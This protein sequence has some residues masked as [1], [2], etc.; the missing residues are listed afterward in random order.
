LNNELIIGIHGESSNITRMS[1]DDN[2]IHQI[3]MKEIQRPIIRASFLHS[4]R[5]ILS[6]DSSGICYLTDIISKTSQVIESSHQNDIDEENW[7]RILNEC[8]IEYDGWAVSWAQLNTSIGRIIITLE[9]N[10]IFQSELFIDDNDPSLDEWK[11]IYNDRKIQDGQEDP[12]SSS[13]ANIG[14][15]FLLSLYDNDNN[16]IYCYSIEEYYNPTSLWRPLPDNAFGTINMLKNI[17]DTILPTWWIDCIRNAKITSEF[18]KM[19]MSFWVK[20]ESKDTEGQRYNAHPMVRFERLMEYFQ[21]QALSSNGDNIDRSISFYCNSH[22]R[23]K[24]DPKL[25][26]G[27]VRQYYWRDKC[28]GQGDLQLYISE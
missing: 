17:D 20:T 4:K 26:L 27:Y 3:E 21:Q 5:K 14:Q 28:Q 24:I 25:T 22:N 19:N 16:G 12:D 1:L 8:N 6:Q 9:Q 10:S 23:I 7:K 11:K 13:R 18:T 15:L 2:S